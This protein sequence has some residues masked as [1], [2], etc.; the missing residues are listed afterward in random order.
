[1]VEKKFPHIILTSVST[2]GNYY[3][4]YEN[5]DEDAKKGYTIFISDSTKTET[6]CECMGFV[7]GKMCYHI[8]EALDKE[9]FL[10]GDSLVISQKQD[11]SKKERGEEREDG[12]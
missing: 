9:K 6:Y 7:H 10:F 1:L 2:N 8:K 12:K 4:A 3:G 11:C 5:S